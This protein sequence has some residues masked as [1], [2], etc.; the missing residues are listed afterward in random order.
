MSRPTKRIFDL[1]PEDCRGDALGER[2]KV[3]FPRWV[4]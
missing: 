3:E 4:F 2:L 1:Q